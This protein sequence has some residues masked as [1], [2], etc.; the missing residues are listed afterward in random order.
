MSEK[1]EN[2]NFTEL[3]AGLEDQFGKALL[4]QRAETAV[5]VAEFSGAVYRAA[6]SSGV[7]ADLAQAMAAGYWDLEMGEASPQDEAEEE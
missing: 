7:P 1:S 6:V 2:E 3:L 5:L 4:V